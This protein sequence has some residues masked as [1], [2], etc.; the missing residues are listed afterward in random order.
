MRK[1]FTPL[2][3]V[4]PSLLAVGHVWLCFDSF[5]PDGN[6]WSGFLA[7][8]VDLPISILFAKL[9]NA[10]SLS[11]LIVFL[12]GGTIWWFCLGLLISLLIGWVCRVVL[13]LTPPLDIKEN[14][15]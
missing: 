1:T 11:A 10:F 2:Y 15:K 8:L 12:I 6:G 14:R 3:F 4:A 9:S 7:F 5:R 13:R